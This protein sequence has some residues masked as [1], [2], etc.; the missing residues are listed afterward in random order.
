MES[1]MTYVVVAP[2]YWAADDELKFALVRI[3]S[4]V[5]HT[6][7]D[8]KIDVFHVSEDWE[9][10][11]FGIRATKLVKM[12]GMTIKPKIAEQAWKIVDQLEDI[13]EAMLIQHDRASET[14]ES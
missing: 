11:D 9:L 6:K 4:M 12:P 1:K 8:I 13:S 3:L 14:S 5:S 7:G 2:S 10:T